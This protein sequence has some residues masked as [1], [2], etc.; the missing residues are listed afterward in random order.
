[1][2]QP[3][4]MHESPIGN[5]NVPFGDRHAVELLA[6]CLV[7]QREKAEPFR[8][9][10]KGAVQPPQAIVLLCCS[11]RLWDRRAIDK[12]N[13]PAMRRRLAA[14][15]LADQR[16]EPGLAIAQALQQRNVGEVRQLDGRRPGAGRAKPHAAQAISQHKPKQIA[17]ASRLRGDKLDRPRTKEGARL[18]AEASSAAAPPSRVKVLCQRSL[19]SVSGFMP[20]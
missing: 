16:F 19:R 20:C 15:Q 8:G 3:V 6:T 10:V 9:E 11:A 12:A 14:E 2:R 7:G 13:A 4:W 1:M 17:G 18:A 5:E